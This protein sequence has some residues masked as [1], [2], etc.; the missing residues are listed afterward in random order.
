ML[1]DLPLEESDDQGGR[2]S[3]VQTANSWTAPTLSSSLQG[4]DACYIQHQLNQSSIL[5]NDLSNKDKD[6]E[7]VDEDIIKDGDEDIKDNDLLTYLRFNGWNKQDA[8]RAQ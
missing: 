2:R 6:D 3:L 4:L 1:G 7:E 8:G 5:I